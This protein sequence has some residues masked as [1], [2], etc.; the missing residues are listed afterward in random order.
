MKSGVTL[1]VDIRSPDK[2]VIACVGEVVQVLSADENGL[3]VETADGRVSFHV[4]RSEVTE[5]SCDA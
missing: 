2:G 5:D 3:L 4:D 1:R